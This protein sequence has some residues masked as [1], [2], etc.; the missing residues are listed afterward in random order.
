M[1]IRKNP[2][3]LHLEWHFLHEQDQ[4][5]PHT[6]TGVNKDSQEPRAREQ[7]EGEQEEM[8]TKVAALSTQSRKLGL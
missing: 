5:S 2:S 3:R 8:L 1:R 4:A 7:E 6:E